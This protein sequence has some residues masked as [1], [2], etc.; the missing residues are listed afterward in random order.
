LVFNWIHNLDTT[1]D[2]GKSYARM[3]V[4]GINSQVKLM[5]IKKEDVGDKL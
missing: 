3:Y 4:R 2:G 5:A 1:I